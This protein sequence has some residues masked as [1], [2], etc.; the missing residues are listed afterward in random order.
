MKYEDGLMDKDD[1]S[2]CV[3]FIHFY[4]KNA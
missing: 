1:P 3:H 2:L 4:A